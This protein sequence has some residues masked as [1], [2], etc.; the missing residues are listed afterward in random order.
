MIPHLFQD[1][2]DILFARAIYALDIALSH[3]ENK[4]WKDFFSYLRSSW[5]QTSLYKISFPLVDKE[6]ESMEQKVEYAIANVNTV[7]VQYAMAGVMK[8]GLLYNLY[9]IS[10]VKILQNNKY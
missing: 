7:A 9:N 8:G 2:L 4:Y 1:K 3:F 5:I 10:K 6:F